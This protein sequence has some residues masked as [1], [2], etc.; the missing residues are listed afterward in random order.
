MIKYDESL[1]QLQGR[2]EISLAIEEIKK[3]GND[4]YIKYQIFYN[5]V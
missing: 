5:Y 3:I 4:E 2:L 1:E